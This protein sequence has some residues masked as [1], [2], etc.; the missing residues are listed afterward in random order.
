MSQTN[1]RYE[2]RNDL[3]SRG[4]K[5]VVVY[6]VWDREAKKQVGDTFGSLKAARVWAEK[7]A[8]N[9]AK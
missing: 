1:Q 7:C 9:K 2:I 8:T 4:G 5:A 6:T 3:A